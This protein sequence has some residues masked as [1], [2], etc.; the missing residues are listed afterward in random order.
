MTTPINRIKVLTFDVFGTL[1]DY[2][3]CP[4]IK[5]YAEEVSLVKSGTKPYRV[6]GKIFEEIGADW[7]K[8]TVKPGVIEGLTR[9]A[10][11]F[12]IIP[13]SNADGQLSV[14][15]GEHFKLPWTFYIPT[16]YPSVFKPDSR[17]YYSA[18]RYLHPFLC[19]EIC[20][21]AAHPYDLIGAQ[22]L[23]L[24]TAFVDW[25]NDPLDP[26]SSANFDYTASDFLTLV[27]MLEASS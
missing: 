12:T 6:L 27:G 16:E 17:F 26:S 5:Q 18:I 21:V 1:L 23:G 20:H 24:Q 10:K 15:I 11:K 3:D 8:L 9:L 13:L 7:T 19:K 14:H 2:S 25:D 22:R 4:W